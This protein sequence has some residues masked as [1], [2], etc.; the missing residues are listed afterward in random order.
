MNANKYVFEQTGGYNPNGNQFASYADRWTPTNPSND[1][2][3]LRYNSK[4]DVDKVARMSSRYIEDA[5]FLRLKTISLSY[6]LPKNFLKLLKIENILLT[7][8]AQNLWTL[9]KYSGANPE[10]SNFR[11]VNSS[12]SPFGGTGSSNGGVGYSFVQPSSSYS[13]LTP[14]YDYTAYPTTITMNFGASITF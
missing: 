8:S 9:T 1:I 4:T 10:A 11:S 14:A 12:S 13:A 5:S 3:R 7:A 2:P 6:S